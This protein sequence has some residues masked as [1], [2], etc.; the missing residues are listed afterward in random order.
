MKMETSSRLRVHA[1]VSVACA[2]YVK[3]TGWDVV[4]DDREQAR[5]RTVFIS[6]SWT[7]LRKSCS[8]RCAENE[9]KMSAVTRNFQILFMISQAVQLQAS[10]WLEKSKML[11]LSPAHTLNY[12]QHIRN[13]I[14]VYSSLDSRNNAVKTPESPCCVKNTVTRVNAIFKEE[15]KIFRWSV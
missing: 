4:R 6:S 10:I 3:E 7:S 1:S 15:F 5:D 13:F 12:P 14:F 2:L 9:L 11:P 8:H